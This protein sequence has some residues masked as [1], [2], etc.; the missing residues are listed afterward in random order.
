M[1][2]GDFYDGVIDL[3][4]KFVEA[5]QDNFGKIKVEGLTGL[6]LSIIY[7]PRNLK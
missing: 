3:I 5:H 4:D 6:Y 7:K 1:A 2:L